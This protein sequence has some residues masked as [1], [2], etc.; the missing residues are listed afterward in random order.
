MKLRYI[1][2]Q[3]FY[4]MRIG[5]KGWDMFWAITTLALAMIAVYVFVGSLLGLIF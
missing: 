4:T 5:P 3:R 2:G 1:D